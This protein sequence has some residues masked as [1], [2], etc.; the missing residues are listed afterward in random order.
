MRVLTER[1][2]WDAVPSGGSGRR[3][4]GSG[5]PLRPNGVGASDLGFREKKDYELDRLAD[6]ELIAYLVRARR[7]ANHAAAELAMAIFANRHFDDLARSAML[8]LKHWEDAED[9]AQQAIE[10]VLKTAF[11]GEVVAEA[12]GLLYRILGRRIA[13]LYRDRER[14]PVPD[15]L[16][17]DLDDDDRRRGDVA[18][19]QDATGAIDLRDVAERRYEQRS[20]AHRLVIDLYVYGGYGGVETATMVNDAFPD[21]DPPMSESNVHQIAK[22]FREDLRADLEDST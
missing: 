22:R 15:A 14:R 11:R 13:D 5:R 7:A 18:V 12:M 4:S 10:G 8:K 16:P 20:P 17:E 19:E 1:L 6:E 21:L 2:S 3:A 9:C